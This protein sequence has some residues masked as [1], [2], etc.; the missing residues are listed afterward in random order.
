MS[1]GVES[2][3]DN[4]V[5]SLFVDVYEELKEIQ[6]GLSVVMDQVAALRDLMKEASPQFATLFSERLEYWQTQETSL[7]A[8]TNALFDQKIRQLRGV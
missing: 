1:P 7:R 4:E 6:G 3:T 2:M 5:R 8:E